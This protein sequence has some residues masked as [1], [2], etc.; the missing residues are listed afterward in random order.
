MNTHILSL[1]LG[2]LGIMGTAALVSIAG[3]VMWQYRGA[4]VGSFRW[5]WR[6]WRLMQL[7]AVACLFFLAM[8]AS[9]GV[10][11][12]VWT[13]IYLIA[14]F[15]SASWWVRYALSRRA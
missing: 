4:R 11:G 1:F 12:D 8:A 7:S 15:K 2:G 6:N 5:H 9:Y 14:A 3:I 13:W 10:L